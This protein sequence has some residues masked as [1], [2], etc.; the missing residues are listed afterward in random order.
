[1]WST[2]K[3]HV[4]DCIIINMTNNHEKRAQRGSG[5]AGTGG[6]AS[7]LALLSRGQE[8]VK[9]GWTSQVYARDA[10]GRIVEPQSL[11]RGASVL[12]AP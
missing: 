8:L 7:V 6:R 10:S 9:A 4:D 1:M 11:Q 5:A 12:S 3:D 2:L